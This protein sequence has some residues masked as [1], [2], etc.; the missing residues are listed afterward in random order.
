[1]SRVRRLCSPRNVARF[2]FLLVTFIWMIVDLSLVSSLHKFDKFE[3]NVSDIRT[4]TKPNVQT[5]RK[6]VAITTATASGRPSRYVPVSVLV[7]MVADRLKF[8][9]RLLHSI[10]SGTRLPGQVIFSISKSNRGG[11]FGDPPPIRTPPELDVVFV[12]SE[13]KKHAAENRNI[14][15]SNATMPILAFLDSD[16]VAGPQWMETVWHVFGTYQDVDALL[17][18][19]FPCN[20]RNST[21]VYTSPF[22]EIR[23]LPNRSTLMDVNKIFPPNL[24]DAEAVKWVA[25]PVALSEDERGSAPARLIGEGYTH[26]YFVLGHVAVRRGVWR[27]VRQREG[28]EGLRREDSYFVADILQRGYRTLCTDLKLTGYCK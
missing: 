3:V 23:P 7:P 1:M 2:L 13:G 8:A 15:A 12:R 21:A 6:G 27:E 11:G 18:L 9:P 10:A 16:D 22:P 19:S 25:R 24:S 20:G 5:E 4:P 28:R 26:P 14:A 17:H